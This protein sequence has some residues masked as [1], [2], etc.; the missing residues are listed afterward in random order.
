MTTFDLTAYQQKRN[1]ANG[2]N[3]ED[4]HDNDISQFIGPDGLTKEAQVVADRFQ[5]VRNLIG[6]LL[7]SRGVPMILGGDEFGRTQ[8]GNNNAYCQDNPISWLDWTLRE[9]NADLVKFVTDWIALR[10]SEPA[11]RIARF[12]DDAIDESTLDLV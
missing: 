12:P 5:R 7:V 11:L 4:G 6:T 8:H 1:Y 10:K 9:S 3:N 2:D